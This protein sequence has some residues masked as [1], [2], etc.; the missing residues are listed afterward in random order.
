MSARWARHRESFGRGCATA[1]LVV[2]AMLIGQACL[3][4]SP[5]LPATAPVP[6]QSPATPPDTGTSRSGIRADS[7]A[8]AGVAGPVRSVKPKTAEAAPRCGAR[9]S[10]HRRRRRCAGRRPVSED[11]DDLEA[12]VRRRKN[13]YAAT[14]SARS[15]STSS[16][17]EPLSDPAAGCF[18][19][20]PVTLKSL[21]KTIKLAPEA[22]LNC[23][24]ARATA[25]FMQDVAG[26]AAKARPRFRPDVDQPCL[27]LCLP[28]AQRHDETLRARFRQRH[29]HRE[30]RPGRRPAHRRQ[31]RR[32]GKDGRLSRRDSQGGVRAV[33]DRAR[34][35]QRCRPRAAFPFR[36]GAAPQ[37]LDLLPVGRSEAA[38]GRISDTGVNCGAELSFTVGG[39]P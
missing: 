30:L 32:R 29:R 24:M 33:Q 25:R 1:V 10:G 2:A 7:G 21:G 19:A 16:R 37:R 36:P 4:A 34:S 28:A 38:L 31:G 6:T 18:V 15:A 39:Y 26:P 14:I 5:K 35:G 3:A 20:N 13:S 22:I 27:G 9:P 8:A 23:N 12:K 11:A 17:H